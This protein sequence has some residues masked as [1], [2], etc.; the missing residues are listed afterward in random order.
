MCSINYYDIG[1]AKYEDG[2][3]RAFLPA[4][5]IKGTLQN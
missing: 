3:S 5:S 1:N 2:F 4:Q